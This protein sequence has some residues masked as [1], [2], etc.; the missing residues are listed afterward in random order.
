MLKCDI[1]MLQTDIPRKAYPLIEH[2]HRPLVLQIQKTFSLQP[3][4]VSPTSFLEEFGRDLRFWGSD[5]TEGGG[6]I[7]M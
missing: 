6:Q 5:N 1:Y 3:N 2:P 7:C 4:S